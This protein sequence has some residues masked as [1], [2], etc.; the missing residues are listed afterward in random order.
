MAFWK[1]DLAEMAQV[2]G[3]A[4]GHSDPLGVAIGMTAKEIK[5][6]APVG[7]LIAYKDFIYDQLSNALLQV[8]R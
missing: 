1:K 8:N 6:F 2:I 4:F 5:S 3:E 7:A